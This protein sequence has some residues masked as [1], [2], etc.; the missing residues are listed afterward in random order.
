MTRKTDYDVGYGKPPKATRFK[1]GESGNPRGRKKGS[2]NISTLVQ[3]AMSETVVIN[4][5]GRRKT[6]TKLEAACMQQANKAAAGD[7]KAWQLMSAVLAASEAGDAA[8]QE[9]VTPEAQRAQ[10]A[11]LLAA[12]RDRITGGGDGA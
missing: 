9:V 10:D 11:K 1:P 3:E 8:A 4:I 7:Q 2:K 5:G 6:V 12:L